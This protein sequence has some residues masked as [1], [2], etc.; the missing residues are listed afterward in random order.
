M[1]KLV[2]M[3]FR[4]SNSMVQLHIQVPYF[5]LNEKEY[6]ELRNAIWLHHFLRYQANTFSLVH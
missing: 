3:I 1:E 6:F 2:K 5:S 4:N